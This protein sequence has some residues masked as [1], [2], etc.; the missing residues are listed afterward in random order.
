MESSDS[1]F[2]GEGLGRGTGGREIENKD[3]ES[4]QESPYGLIIVWGLRTAQMLFEGAYEHPHV[5]A[6]GTRSINLSMERRCITDLSCPVQDFLIRTSDL[7]GDLRCSNCEFIAGGPEVGSPRG[8]DDLTYD[9]AKYLVSGRKRNASLDLN[10]EHGWIALCI[11]GMH[12]HVIKWSS[13]GRT[14]ERDAV[15]RSTSK[16]AGLRAR[17]Q[18]Q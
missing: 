9:C 4:T 3:L 17:Q 2:L 1:T 6:G 11:V 5:S 15:D 8:F 12:D 14:L 16:T 18:G 10:L 7:A 13:L